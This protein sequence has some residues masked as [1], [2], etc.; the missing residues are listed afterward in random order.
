MRLTLITLV[1]LVTAV[2]GCHGN[3][4]DPTGGGDGSGPGSGSSGGRGGSGGGSGTTSSWR[5]S[6]E[7]CDAV[8][9]D[10]TPARLLTQTEY[11]NTVADLVGDETRPL[12]RSPSSVHGGFDNEAIGVSVSPA[13]M[14]RYVV[15][16]SEIAEGVVAGDPSG[17]VPCDLV[18]GDRA[19]A[20][21]LVQD[22][23]PRA[24]RR[25]L[26]AGEA[27]ALLAL[28]DV[29]AADGG[30]RAGVTTVIEAVLASP[31][32]LYH[33]EVGEP[34]AEDAAITPLT[35][36]EVASRLSYFLWN[37]MPDEALFDAA[38]AGE[39]QTKEGILAHAERL[40][41]DPRARR[42][43]RNMHA[44]W[45]ELDHLEEAMKDAAL[46]PEW[47][48]ELARDLRE[49]TLAFL[50]ELVFED[51]TVD[52]I[53]LSPFSMMNDRVAAFYG[54]PAPGTGDAFTRVSVD[55]EQRAGVL[56]QASFLAANAKTTR[57]SPIHRGAFVRR[58]ILCQTLPSPPPG[59]PMLP[60]EVEGE[61]ERARLARHREDPTCAGCHQLMDPIGFTFEHYDAAGRWTN[62]GGDGNPVDA[63]GE[64]VS[65]RD[66]DGPVD[67][68]LELSQQLAE[69]QEVRECVTEQWFR[70]AL[71]RSPTSADGCSVREVLANGEAT[72]WRLRDLIVAITQ[73]DAFRMR[74]MGEVGECR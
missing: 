63:S 13:L 51:G 62:V 52:G 61:T 47:T 11:N 37:T 44:Q 38:A 22:L 1:L 30:F 3:I 18:S 41:D 19:C 40:L 7:S 32:F 70:Y 15:L 17:V 10:H 66:S 33:V 26:E 28:Y 46:F 65:S 8:D 57:T 35:G 67:G 68:A 20:E 71:A 45:L 25:P 6:D 56:T 60:D 23:G 72:G 53:F 69:S 16:A 43:I 55:A 24:Y 49:E 2:A 14:E 54:L 34:G 31:D 12:D 64:I 36:Y 59:I 42:A 74:R 5:E 50:D 27:E 29:A 48:P 9:A 73:T 21:R 39:L 4:A 58:R